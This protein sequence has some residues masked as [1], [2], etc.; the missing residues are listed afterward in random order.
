MNRPEMAER[1]FSLAVPDAAV[2]ILQLRA[3]TLLTN[4]YHL[5]A[6]PNPILANETPPLVA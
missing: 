6:P 3:D 2:I 1:V 5:E 4:A